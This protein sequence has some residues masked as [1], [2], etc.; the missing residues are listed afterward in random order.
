MSIREKYHIPANGKILLY[1]GNISDNKNQK[2]MVDACFLLTENMRNNTWILFCGRPSNEGRFEDYVNNTTYSDHLVLCGAVEKH[3]ISN[4]YKEADG[5]VL[6]SVAEG[7]GLSLIEG[8]HFGVPGTMFSDMDA[9]EDIYDERS[10]VPIY[11]RDNASVAKA[12]NELLSRKWDKEQI[13][14]HSKKFE[15]QNMAEQYIK[16]YKKAILSHRCDW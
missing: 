13:K 11:N 7:F 9:F 10:I 5:V 14:A 2:Q 4:Y 1:V 16:V 3:E 6:L 12:I 8:M 15:S